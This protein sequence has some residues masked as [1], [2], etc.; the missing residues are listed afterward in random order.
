[1]KISRFKAFSLYFGTWVLA[2]IFFCLFLVSSAAIPN[3]AIKINM[4]KSALSYATKE[5]FAL[6]QGKH[7]YGVADHYADA[8]LLGVAW[9]MGEGSP[10]TSA[11]NTKYYDGEEFGENYGFYLS[12][13]EGRSPNTDYTRY[14]HGTAAF[15]RMFHL[16]TDVDG[17]KIIGSA[18]ILILGITVLVLLILKKHTDIAIVFLISLCSVQIWNVNLSM[19]YQ[20]A[21]IVALALCILCLLSE[22]KGDLYLIGL[23]VISG[24]AVCFF[25]F[26]TTETLTFL[27]P[28]MTVIAVRAKENRLGSFKEGFVISLKCGAAWLGSYIGTFLAKWILVTVVTGENAFIA[29][30]SSIGERIGGQIDGA[31]KLD[32]F[33]SVTTNIGVML[34]SESR[35][36]LPRTFLLLLFIFLLLISVWYLFRKKNGEKSASLLLLLLS[37]AVLFRFLI[38]NNHS[39]LHSF[40]TYRALACVVFAVLMAMWFNIDLPKRKRG[41]K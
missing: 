18:T 31:E 12:V 8:V 17:M 28:L 5:P 14:W 33:S 9:N 3:R 19:E 39:F 2:L 29:A 21:V 41:E 26:L 40:F 15:V 4:E 10:V 30:F 23:F 16:F 1:M 11:L 35:L 24:T 6:S 34:G 27:L 22:K 7:L 25:D 38:L 20:P 37:S 13:T 36:P 32:I